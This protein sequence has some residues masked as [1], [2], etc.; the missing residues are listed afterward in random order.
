MLNF[1]QVWRKLRFS[2]KA[3][4]HV[5]IVCI[6]FVVAIKY[7]VVNRK[8]EFCFCLYFFCEMRFKWSLNFKKMIIRFSANVKAPKSTPFCETSSITCTLSSTDIPASPMTRVLVVT[9]TWTLRPLKYLYDRQCNTNQQSE[10]GKTYSDI[11]FRSI[12]VIYVL[13]EV[14]LDKNC[15]F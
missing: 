3:N 9:I 7:T 15:P 13:I 4:H 2:S 1:Y 11:I 14:I 10:R 8:Y 6:Y 5:K 12:T